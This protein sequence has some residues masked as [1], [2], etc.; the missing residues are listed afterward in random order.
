MT[1]PPGQHAIDGFPRFGTHL[2]KPPPAV[3]AAPA[4]EI[5]GAV[6]DPLTV[7]LDDLTALPRT[8]QTSDFHCVAGW[9]ASHR[10]KVSGSVSNAPVGSS[11]PPASPRPT[12]PGTGTGSSSRRSSRARHRRRDISSRVRHSGPASSDRAGGEAARARSAG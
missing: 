11:A 9:S 6:R 4:V 12:A 10:S 8:D 3:P 5:A 7:S 2:D 1:L